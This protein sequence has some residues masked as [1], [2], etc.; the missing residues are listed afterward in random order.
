MTVR[1]EQSKILTSVITPIPTTNVVKLENQGLVVPLRTKSTPLTKL[2]TLADKNCFNGLA[3]VST[4]VSVS[5]TR[6]H[7]KHQLS[8]VPRLASRLEWTGTTPRANTTWFVTNTTHGSILLQ[9]C[10]GKEMSK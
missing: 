8:L 2:T 9:G 10:L 4:Q 6:K 7:S 1:T 3:C 5:L